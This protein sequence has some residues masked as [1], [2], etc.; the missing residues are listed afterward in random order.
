M[1]SWSFELLGFRVNVQPTFLL[2]LGV[3][4]LFQL[5]VQEPL[6]AIVSWALVVFFSILIHELGHALVAR[7]FGLRVGDIEIHGLGGHV[8]HARTT[9]RRQLAISLAGP[10]AGL[11]LGFGTLALSL[12]LPPTSGFVSELISDILFVNIV[13]SVINL[14]PMYPLDGG[15]ALRSGLSL[16]TTERSAWRVTAMCGITLG[17]AAVILGYT[18]TFGG[19][20]MIFLGGYVAW[21]NMQVYQHFA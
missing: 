1:Q 18:G 6:S 10:F 8:T 9:P 20:F 3:Y 2:L 19:T 16:F 5:Q 7:R 21:Q 14:L 4:L 17:I 15:N 11:T 12:V 13:W